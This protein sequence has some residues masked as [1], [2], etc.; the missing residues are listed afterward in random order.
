[1][2]KKIR[3]FIIL[4]LAL[5]AVAAGGYF[6]ITTLFPDIF[7]KNTGQQ[8]SKTT[9]L[10]K[11]DKSNVITKELHVNHDDM[12]L[13]GTF[14]APSNYESLQLPLVILSPG[15]NMN[16][17]VLNPVAQQVA[18]QG[19][20]VYS[21]D[22]YG[23]ST[24]TRSGD[25]DMMNMTLDTEKADLNAVLSYWRSQSFVDTNHVYLGGV[26]HGGLISSLVA[27]ER[28]ADVKAMVLLAP[29]FN[30]PDVVRSDMEQLGYTD[31]EQL[32]D[33]VSYQGQS[34]SKA[35]IASALNTDVSAAQRAY[36][37]NVLIIHGTADDMVPVSYSEAAAQTFPHAELMSVEGAGHEVSEIAAMSVLLKIQQFMS[38]N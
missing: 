20:M 16:S 18:T 10:L 29:A 4:L 23:G 33:I 3:T 17:D 5:V 27:A 14:V 28:P 31:A 37:G 2:A 8:I 15:L 19:Y 24:T 34:V 1:M 35:Y 36:S 21:F 26:S 25:T 9:Q 38:A 22:F 13:Y 12:D 32:P 6:A 30:V 7:S 11:A